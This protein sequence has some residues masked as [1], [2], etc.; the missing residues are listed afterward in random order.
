[1]ISGGRGV[2]GIRNAVAVAVR[3]VSAIEANVAHCRNAEG[4]SGSVGAGSRQLPSTST[5]RPLSQL[6]HPLHPPLNSK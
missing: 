5:C 4:R 1:M 3:I 6:H 2:Y